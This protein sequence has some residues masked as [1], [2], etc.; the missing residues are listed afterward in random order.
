[1]N[2]NNYRNNTSDTPAAPHFRLAAQLRCTEKP[3]LS[4]SARQSYEHYCIRFGN[5]A[6]GKYQCPFVLNARP[7]VKDFLNHLVEKGYS[8][9]TVHRYACALKTLYLCEIT[10]FGVVLP[11][12]KKKDIT[13]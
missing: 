13:K 3:S 9:Y 11:Q 5:W 12:R 1:M 10:D 7:F 4:D 6:W 8:R 2:I